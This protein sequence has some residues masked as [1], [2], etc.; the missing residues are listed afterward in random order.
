MLWR[1]EA[2]PLRILNIS[3]ACTLLSSLFKTEHCYPYTAF[4]LVTLEMQHWST[5]KNLITAA[6]TSNKNPQASSL[7][8]NIL[9]SVFKRNQHVHPHRGESSCL[10]FHPDSKH[11]KHSWGKNLF[12]LTLTPTHLSPLQKKKKLFDSAAPQRSCRIS[13]RH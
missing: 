2:E 10:T 1:N 3:N 5:L 4:P 13:S 9:P 7:S 11:H 12:S 8:Q 6:V